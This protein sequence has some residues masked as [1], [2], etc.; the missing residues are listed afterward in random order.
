MPITERINDMYS[1]ILAPIR[2]TLFFTTVLCYFLVTAPLYFIVRKNPIQG[3]KIL[4]PILSFFSRFCLLFMGIGV[5]KRNLS[6]QELK[7][8]GNLF[9]CNHLSYLDVLILASCYKASFVTSVEIKNTPFLGQLCQLAGCVFVER[10]NKKNI[11]LEVKEITDSLANGINVVIFP[12]ATSTNGESVIRFRRPLFQAAIDSQANIAPLTLNYRALSG[13]RVD[14]SNRDEIFWYGDMT[15]IDHLWGVFK[16]DYV[17]SELII[18]SPL[19]L[20][21]EEEVLPQYLAETSHK[22]VSHHYEP[23]VAL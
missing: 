17:N 5:E 8:S 4:N 18:E 7:S 23:I 20:K 13:K 22:I 21:E 15:F 9:V 19:N 16:Q 1:Q 3:R 12:E 6:N 11:S 10:R 2:M 14:L